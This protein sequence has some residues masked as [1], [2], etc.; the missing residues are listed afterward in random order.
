MEVFSKA[1]A[2]GLPSHCPYD[3][4]IDLLP[5]TKTCNRIYPLSLIEQQLM[6]E[7]KRLSSRVTLCPQLHLGA[8]K[9]EKK[10]G[11]IHPCIDYRGL[12]KITEKYFYPLL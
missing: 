3:C 5:S 9:G 2:S 1:K 4:M 11:G 8:F 10:R 7:Y 6:E 12:N